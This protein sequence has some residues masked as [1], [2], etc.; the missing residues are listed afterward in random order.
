M[1]LTMVHLL[2]ADR[3]AQGH[4]QYA[5]SPEFFLGAVSP[6]AIHIRD[7]DDKSH[8][9][10]FHLYNWQS[11]HRE[12]LEAYWRDHAAPFD[13][14]YGVHVLTDCQWVPRYKERLPGVFLPTGKLDIPVYYNDTFVTDFALCR[15]LPRLGHLLEL[16]E[17]SEVPADHPLLTEYE[18]AEW[19]RVI[20][21]AYRGP[22]PKNDPVKCIDERYVLDFVEDSIALIDEIYGEVFPGAGQG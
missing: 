1:A 13:I 18:F 11:L 2:V 14:G 7:H 12:P 15:K 5:E 21:E 22:C 6:D 4:P 17:R 19:R 20:L 16:M 9:D 8:K 3:W 10:E